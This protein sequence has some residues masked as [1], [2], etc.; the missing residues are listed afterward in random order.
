[1]IKFKFARIWG[2]SVRF[3]GQKIM[4]TT[5]ILQDQDILELHMK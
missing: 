5:H 1:L 4:K 3:D 2:K